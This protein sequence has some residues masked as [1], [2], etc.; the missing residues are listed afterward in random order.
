MPGLEQS[1]QQPSSAEA[2]CTQHNDDQKDQP[3]EIEVSPPRNYRQRNRRF[4][5]VQPRLERIR[6]AWYSTAFDQRLQPTRQSATKLHRCAGDRVGKF[7][8]AR[9]ER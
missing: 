2:E 9:M 5:V 3:Q 6:L 8:L 4:R 7:Q 1:R